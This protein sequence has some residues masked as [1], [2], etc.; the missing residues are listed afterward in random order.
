MRKTSDFFTFFNNTSNNLA[1]YWSQFVSYKNSPI[2][3]VFP[4]FYFLEFTF[5]TRTSPVWNAITQKS[6]PFR[7]RP[8]FILWWNTRKWETKN[9]TK[10]DNLKNLKNRHSKRLQPHSKVKKSP[11]L[12]LIWI[13][14]FRSFRKSWIWFE[15]SSANKDG[16]RHGVTLAFTISFF[17]C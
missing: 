2:E 9:K 4:V 8:L 14:C 3:F 10:Q 11:K 1:R 6:K 5:R 15:F 13:S 7:V 16:K 12:L 17:E